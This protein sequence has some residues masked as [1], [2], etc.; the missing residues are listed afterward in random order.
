MN[1]NALRIFFRPVIIFFILIN[2]LCLTWGKWLTAKGVDYEALIYANLILFLLTLIACYI[3]IR[4]LANDNPYAFVRSI[5]LASFIKLIAIGISVVVYFLYAE[6]KNIY[7]I[8]IAMI[9]YI[10]YTIFEVK[11]AMKL[12]R[13]RNAKN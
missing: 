9:F 8:A 11:G 3:H 2:A 4:T 10:V 7:S 1:K 12:N 5:T 13:E 6:E